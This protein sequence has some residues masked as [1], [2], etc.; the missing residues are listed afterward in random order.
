[1]LALTLAAMAVARGATAAVGP[2]DFRC[3][4]SVGQSQPVRLEFV[5]ADGPHHD[6]YVV[7]EH[8]HG[9]IPVTQ[10]EMKELAAA[11][12]GPAEFRT[13]WRETGP[14]GGE[15]VMDSQG[16]VVYDFRYIRKRDGK[17]FRFEEDVQ[18]SGEHR[19]TWIST[20]E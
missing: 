9:K 8:G 20:G 17:V 3:F 12:N 5:L 19:C 1:M 15:Y 13:R 6:S 14:D 18:S 2:D 16:A 11:P 10:V 4:K 7:Y